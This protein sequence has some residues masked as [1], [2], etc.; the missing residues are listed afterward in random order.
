M[1][2]NNIIR[3]IRLSNIYKYNSSINQRTIS[4]FLSSKRNYSTPQEESEPMDEYE[5]KI[6]NI[7]QQ[8]LNPVNLKIKDVS[9][10]CGSMFSIFIES[11]KFKGL[12]MIKQHR[13]VNEILKDEIK[14]WHGLQL[15]TKKV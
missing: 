9:G 5:S 6:Y 14:K 13:L 12:T 15:R 2:R 11:E 3:N 4:P 10:G 8:E 1:I 7:L